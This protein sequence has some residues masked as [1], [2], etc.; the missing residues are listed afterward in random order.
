MCRLCPAT[1]VWHHSPSLN[2]AR[3]AWIPHKKLLGSISWEGRGKVEEN[4]AVSPLLTGTCGLCSSTCGQAC[5]LLTTFPMGSTTPHSTFFVCLLTFQ[6]PL[7]CPI[8]FLLSIG[9][10]SAVPLLWFLGCF[11]RKYTWALVHYAMFSW[12]C[13]DFENHFLVL[14]TIWQLGSFVYMRILLWQSSSS[15]RKPVM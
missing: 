12:P 3:R 6:L 8:L 14:G 10:I 9:F 2:C 11:Q 15:P 7:S 1:S 4:R 5:F 13:R